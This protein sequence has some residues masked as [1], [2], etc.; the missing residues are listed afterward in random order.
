MHLDI[1]HNTYSTAE[2]RVIAEGLK[3][4]RTLLGIHA[5]GNDCE[6]DSRGFMLPKDEIPLIEVGHFFKRM[7]TS[8]GP[9]HTHTKTNCWICEKWVEVT[10][11]WTPGRSGSANEEPIFIHL[12]CD[13]FQPEYLPKQGSV[14][15]ITRAVPPGP[16]QFFFSHPTDA[17]VSLSYPQHHPKRPLELSVRFW[18]GLTKTMTIET[19]NLISASGPVCELGNPFDTQ[20]R[21]PPFPYLPPNIARSKTPWSIP[22]SLFKDYKFDNDV[23]ARQDTFNKCFE[24][25]WKCC[26]VPK[27]IKEESELSATKEVLRTHYRHM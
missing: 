2:C 15:K 18:E 26:K 6:V 7:L 21:T 12:E 27:L 3:E 23:S 14:F 10:F 13:G 1:S 5:H 24:F 9:E 19:I 4:N 20:P 11:E 16:L 25:D 8:R 17:T 22:I